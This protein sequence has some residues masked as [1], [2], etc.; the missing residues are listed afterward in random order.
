LSVEGCL[1]IL[2]KRQSLPKDM[3]VELIFEVDHLP[4]RVRGQVREARSDKMVGF[5]FFQ[6]NERV[7]RNLKD[8]VE[9]LKGNIVKRLA[10]I[11]AHQERLKAHEQVALEDTVDWRARLQGG[12]TQWS[13]GTGRHPGKPHSG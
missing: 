5:Q 13:D 7:R 12:A 6:V 10:E 11:K 4:F 8:L 9:E 3:R 1:L 2:R